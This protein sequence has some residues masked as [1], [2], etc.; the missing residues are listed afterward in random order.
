MW[1]Y[2]IA[3]GRAEQVVFGLTALWTVLV[4]NAC[5]DPGWID[6]K[7]VDRYKDAFGEDQ[8][9]MVKRAYKSPHSERFVARFDHWFFFFGYDVGALNHIAHH[10]V[11]V[12]SGVIFIVMWFLT[13]W[14]YGEM[15]EWK[16]WWFCP[17][18]VWEFALLTEYIVEVYLRSLALVFSGAS[19]AV[20][21]YFGDYS[22]LITEAWAK[23]NFI[24]LLYYAPVLLGL[25]L[26]Y[27][28]MGYCFLFSYHAFLMACGN[29]TVT[30]EE[31]L[32]QKTAIHEETWSSVK[33]LHFLV[34]GEIVSVFTRLGTYKD[35]VILEEG[36]ELPEGF[37]V[38]S[39]D[40]KWWDGYGT[41]WSLF[42]VF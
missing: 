32:M 10:A 29:M 36:G 11:I 15:T 1:F 3:E 8:N 31:E 30:E 14:F 34:W 20:R 28:G 9:G 17:P 33:G 6:E 2:Y 22:W 19:W 21:W 26:S 16:R 23:G 35:V 40:G 4:M 42:F 41:V 7:N 25:L 38:L 12:V 39:K 24:W 5:R 13:I 18:I 37:T 27:Y